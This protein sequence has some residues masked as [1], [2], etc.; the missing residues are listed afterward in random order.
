MRISTFFG[1]LLP[2]LAGC[3]KKADSPEPSQAPTSVVVKPVI[4]EASGIADSRT[5]AGALWV[6]EDSGNPPQLSLLGH[7]GNLIKK[8]LL[9]N[10][11]NRDWED[12]ALSGGYV[13]IGDIGDNDQKY[14]SCKIYKLP[15]PSTNATDV[16][17]FET[18]EFVYADGP[19]DAEAFLVDP[20]SGD[21][22]IITKRDA[23]AGIY[24]VKT[25]ISTSAINTAEKVGELSFTNVVS[26]T[27]APDGGRL[28]VKTY[29]AIYQFPIFNKEPLSES[30][31]RTPLKLAYAGEPQGEAVSFKQDGTGYFTLSEQFGRN[32]VRLYFYKQK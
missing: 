25:P 8:L 26:A 1:C 18:I 27:L 20:N 9:K 3:Q 24:R 32:E 13:Y 11:A 6:I 5:H 2:F 22:H 7:D 17:S 29:A 15:E 12:V 23:T 14:A 30:L 31:K 21:I 10:A 4:A 16:S 19:H 28:V